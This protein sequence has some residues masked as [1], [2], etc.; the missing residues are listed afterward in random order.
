[1]WICARQDALDLVALTAIPGNMPARQS[2]SNARKALRFFDCG[3]DATIGVGADKPGDETDGFMGSD[4][5]LNMSSGM[6]G[7]LEGS[8]EALA[9]ADVIINSIQQFGTDL[10]IIAVG[11]LVNLAVAEERRPG[12]LQQAGPVLVMGGAFGEGNVEGDKEFN[13][14]FD[15]SS[16]RRVVASGSRLRLFPLDVTSTRCFDQ[17]QV[18]HIA[19]AAPGYR[20]EWFS[21]LF[22]ALAAQ[23]KVWKLDCPLVHDTMPVGFALYPTLFELHDGHFV[24]DTGSRKGLT[25][26]V[27]DAPANGRWA[28][29]ADESLYARFAEDVGKYLQ[30]LP[31]WHDE[32]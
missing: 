27:A 9:A 4:G 23:C 6:G 14:W 18:D 8:G 1:M 29:R 16:A 32:L 11:P 5:M 7:E 25:S 28:H 21:R 30:G 20:T 13:I 22:D 10:T 31:S 15:A 26:L 3:R 24:V 19:A 2:L 12:I 17:Q